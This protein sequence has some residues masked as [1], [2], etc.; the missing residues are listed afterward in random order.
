MENCIKTLLL[1]CLFLVSCSQEPDELPNWEESLTENELLLVGTW[2]YESI[3]VAGEYKPFASPEMEVY[4]NRGAVGGNRADLFRRKIQYA[5]DGTYQLQWVERGDYVLGTEGDPNWQPSFGSW[6][7]IDNTL[8]H[9]PGQY[10][11]ARYDVSLS[12]TNFTRS[13]YRF[14]SAPGENNRWLIG[15]T[16]MYVENFRKAED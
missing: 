8:I 12:Q 2:D 13:A 7:L 5:M 6:Q 4:G 3:N 14:M 1:I 16:I 9:N 15:D 11:E 10:Y